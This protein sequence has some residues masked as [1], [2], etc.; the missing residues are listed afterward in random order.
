MTNSLYRE[1]IFDARSA[2][3]AT[4]IALGVVSGAV[5]LTTSGMKE[6]CTVVAVPFLIGFIIARWW[7]SRVQQMTV[8]LAIG[9]FGMAVRLLVSSI[10]SDK[11]WFAS[12]GWLIVNVGLM[13]PMVFTIV[14][15]LTFP[16]LAGF[17]ATFLCVCLNAKG[18]MIT[19]CRKSR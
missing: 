9:L 6:F 18:P 8:V 19:V 17:F 13:D 2:R 14:L 15:T 16:V 1:R 11:N 4:L 3:W 5:P 12:V 7:S 10:Y